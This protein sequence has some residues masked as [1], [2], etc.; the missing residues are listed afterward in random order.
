[1]IFASAKKKEEEEKKRKRRSNI[2]VSEK[3]PYKRTFSISSMNKGDVNSS[4]SILSKENSSF[5]IYLLV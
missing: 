4:F 3:R 2:D 5:S 1:L